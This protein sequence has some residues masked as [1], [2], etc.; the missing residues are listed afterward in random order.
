MGCCAGKPQGLAR[1]RDK[2]EAGAAQG[3][4][5]WGRGSCL[6]PDRSQAPATTPQLICLQLMASSCPLPHVGAE[7]VQLSSLL[8]L[9]TAACT[10]QAGR[11]LPGL[12]ER[13]RRASASSQMF[14]VIS[15]IV[16]IRTNPVNILIFPMGQP[17]PENRQQQ[18]SHSRRPYNNTP[19]ATVETSPKP[20]Q[21]HQPS[22]WTLQK[23]SHARP[24]SPPTPFQGSGGLHRCPARGS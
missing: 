11:T 16:H 21:S 5:G 22:L 8:V 24:S 17:L 12:G 1:V 2:C 14:P 23:P 19:T 13:R 3:G 9:P 15:G 18:T 20:S 7:P 4:E 10:C 6:P